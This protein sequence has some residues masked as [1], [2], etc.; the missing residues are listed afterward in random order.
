MPPWNCLESQG[1]KSGVRVFAGMS[2]LDA[3]TLFSPDATLEL[4]YFSFTG[5]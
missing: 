5:V 3:H 1:G 4:N 2:M